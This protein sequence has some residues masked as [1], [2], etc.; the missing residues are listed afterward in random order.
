MQNFLHTLDEYSFKKENL[1][2]EKINNINFTAKK[3]KTTYNCAKQTIKAA[4]R[5]NQAKTDTF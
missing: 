3:A 1:I 5:N 4:P 2:I